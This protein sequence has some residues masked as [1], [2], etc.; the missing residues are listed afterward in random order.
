[1]GFKFRIDRP[2]TRPRCTVNVEGMRIDDDTATFNLS[3]NPQ[4]ALCGQRIDSTTYVA[5]ADLARGSGGVESRVRHVVKPI[6]LLE[7]LAAR[8]KSVDK[9]RYV[10]MKMAGESVEVDEL[11]HALEFIN[12]D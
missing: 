9:V 6:E 3:K 7:H 11:L 5:F 12:V 10:G 2:K 8:M 4:L 1:M